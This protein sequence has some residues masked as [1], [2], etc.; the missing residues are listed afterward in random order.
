MKPRTAGV[1]SLDPI[2]LVGRDEQPNVDILKVPLKRRVP[3][4]TTLRI[5]T[6]DMAKQVDSSQMTHSGVL[7]TA[8]R[9][10][11]FDIFAF[12]FTNCEHGFTAI[13]AVRNRS[14]SI[15]CLHLSS[16]KHDEFVFRHLILNCLFS[17]KIHVQ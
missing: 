13:I 9:C 2:S 14:D 17:I 10:G 1:A 7:H 16:A 3:L 4:Y 15:F 5:D 6:P 8:T 12:Q 11:E